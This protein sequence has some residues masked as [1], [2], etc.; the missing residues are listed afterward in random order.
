MK[1][2]TVVHLDLL[3]GQICTL[4]WKARVLGGRGCSVMIGWWPV[5]PSIEFLSW[6]APVVPAWVSSSLFP[7]GAAINRSWPSPAHRKWEKRFHYLYSRQ[8]K[9]ATITICDGK[10]PDVDVANIPSLPSKPWKIEK[11]RLHLYSWLHSLFSWGLFRSIIKGCGFPT[12]EPR[13]EALG[14]GILDCK[15]LGSTDFL[16]RAGFN[17]PSPRH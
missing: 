6:A 2:P 14:M 9:K 15:C 10:L 12:S 1:Y 5:G 13:T 3:I 7:P 8:E 17:W 4:P 11:L 16:T